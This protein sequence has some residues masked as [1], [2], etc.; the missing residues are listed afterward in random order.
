M[1]KNVAVIP[2]SGE[3]I[4]NTDPRYMPIGAAMF[5]LNIRKGK[6]TGYSNAVINMKGNEVL[7][8]DLPAGN[9]TCIGCVEDTFSS[10]LVYFIYNDQGNHGIY[11]FYPFETTER[12][13][14]IF[15][16]DV[17]NFE[18]D[19]PIHSACIIDGKI[20]YWPNARVNL[21]GQ[22]RGLPPR[23]LNLAKAS[24]YQ[25]NLSYLIVLPDLAYA[26]GAVYAYS[27]LDLDGNILVPSTTLY[28]VPG[29]PPSRQTVVNAIV[30]G[31]ASANIDAIYPGVTSE[32]VDYLIITHQ[33]P[34]RV[35]IFTCTGGIFFH[36]YNHYSGL[37]S[38]MLELIKP[39]PKYSIKPV[40][41]VDSEYHENRV[42]NIAFQFRYRYVF[43]DNEKS[44]WSPASYVP[45]N[46]K[47]WN[48]ASTD[49][50]NENTQLYNFIK[51]KFDDDQYLSSNTWRQIIIGIEICVRFSSEGIYQYAGNFKLSDLGFDLIIRFY[52][53][54]VLP[55]VPS[56][57]S[58]LE[59]SQA[60]KNY[61]SVPRLSTCAE[62]VSDESGASFMAWGGNLEG[63]SAD[64]ISA[65]ISVDAHSP[66]SP[67]YPNDQPGHYKCMK[68]GG[69]YKVCVI[70]EDDFG[71]QSVVEL[72]RIRIPFTQIGTN[73]QHITVSFN[74]YPPLWATR[75]R[76]GI[77]QNQNQT[78]YIQLPAFGV[79]YWIHNPTEDTM[80]ATNYGAGDADYV[81]FEFNIYDLNEAVAI[82]N[83]I[84][85]DKENTRIFT[86]QNNDRIQV[87]NW[88]IH[89]GLS[90]LNIQ[91]YNYLIA[92]YNLTYPND[93][94]T[95]P[96][97]RF[98]VFIKF[99]AVQQPDYNDAGSSEGA[100]DWILMEIYR[101]DT[102]NSPD[103]YYEFGGVYDIEDNMDPEKR[104]HGDPVNLSGYGD[105]FASAKKF[106]HQFNGSTVTTVTVP[107]VQRPSL[108]ENSK[109]ILNDLGRVVAFDPDQGEI[110]SYDQIRTTGFFVP[111]SMIN[112]LNAFK[113]GDFIRINKTYGPINKMILLDQVLL[114]V[115]INKSQ[116]I[117][118]GRDR[119]IDLSGKS[120]VGRSASLLTIAQELS[121]DL[122]TFNPESVQAEN[123]R[124]FAFDLKKGVLW[125]YNTGGGQRN[126]SKDAYDKR[127]KLL[128]Q[129]NLNDVC[130]IYSGIDR[131]F[132][133]YFFCMNNE[134]CFGYDFNE[135]QFRGNYSIHQF[136]QLASVSMVTVSFSGGELWVHERGSFCNFYGIQYEFNISPV[137]NTEYDVTKLMHSIAIQTD[138]P[139]KVDSV[140]IPETYGYISGMTSRIP[141]NKFHAYEGL[142][143]ADFLRDETD[144]AAMFQAISNPLER[145]ASALLRGRPLR[146][147]CATIQI[148]FVDPSTLTILHMLKVFYTK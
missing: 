133:T 78:R 120:I 44:A 102:I 72:G 11:R 105:T 37:E 103:I 65:T 39:V 4:E 96:A 8:F 24:T 2:I 112:N 17:L 93:T 114:V 40:Y 110:F 77:S 45:T 56:D 90:S 48:G 27:V 7:A 108:H 51:L 38:Q 79:T 10:T 124:V 23:K 5:A 14:K 141:A 67:I 76:I 128:S 101:P 121:T 57:E 18:V 142:F 75:Y 117:Y 26:T 16:S 19:N 52:N 84:F 99:D 88:D 42:Y 55:V 130:R 95:S 68:A 119:T 61:D 92:G 144:P 87:L 81:G 113:S 1:D 60:L 85:E 100:N 50:E 126:V 12:I 31:L 94:V 32:G 22:I 53:D 34:E 20:L 138:R 83:F 70:Y 134:I 129:S 107:H 47:Q 122:G 6:A 59:S 135:N 147:E 28:T 127:F 91:D 64:K 97:Y 140:V 106:S 132:D 33:T 139:V 136:T 29:G 143:R 21:S 36:P 86:P 146:G 41:S 118:V 9:N 46:F 73:L 71:R 131:K 82:R 89:T 74:N 58:S 63:Y 116:P 66:E 111:N 98:T 62:V 15:E 43:D 80:T 25:K 109:E 148:G 115:A 137:F 49:L 69:S 3:V 13:E 54:S 104:S 123:G 30:T 125:E 35:I 145:L